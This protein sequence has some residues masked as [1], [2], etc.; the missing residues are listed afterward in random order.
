MLTVQNGGW[1]R[2]GGGARGEVSRG[3]PA[4]VPQRES[5]SGGEGRGGGGAGGGGG[6]GRG[7]GGGG[8]GGWP[9]GR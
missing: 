7:G 6:G 4:S 1:L 9:K 8:G 5:A 3:S 2:G